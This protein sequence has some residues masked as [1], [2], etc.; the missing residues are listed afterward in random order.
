MSAHIK[1]AQRERMA[2][3][4]CLWCAVRFLQSLRSEWCVKSG[5]KA[6]VASQIRGASHNIRR[7]FRAVQVL[8]WFRVDDRHKR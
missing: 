5:Q 1:Y 2:S 7:R 4:Y 8:A 3:Y 6:T